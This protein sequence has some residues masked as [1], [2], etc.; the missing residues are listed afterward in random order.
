MPT[1]TQQTTRWRMALLRILGFSH[2]LAG[3]GGRGIPKSTESQALPH[4][5]TGRSLPRGLHPG[6]RSRSPRNS[7]SYDLAP[8]AGAQSCSA[9][10]KVKRKAFCPQSTPLLGQER[11]TPIVTQDYK[12][13][14]TRC[15]SCTCGKLRRTAD[16][17]A[18][19]AGQ[20]GLGERDHLSWSLRH[21]TGIRATASQEANHG[22]RQRWSRQS[23][24]RTACRSCSAMFVTNGEMLEETAQE[25]EQK[26]TE[27]FI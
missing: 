17:Q 5:R 4:L 21:E 1:L 2:P 23:G 14:N 25:A 24:P 12:L 22:Q 26:R 7:T 10:S 18:R 19:Q 20:E 9:K 3:P 13:Q 11:C 6:K 8:R 16:T 15:A 27:P